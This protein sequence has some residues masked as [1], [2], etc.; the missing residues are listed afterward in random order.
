MWHVIV[1]LACWC[2]VS[3]VAGFML[4]RLFRRTASLPLHDV[5]TL[6]HAPQAADDS[7]RQPVNAESTAPREK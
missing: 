4:A 3:I 5:E 7:T 6:E 2:L 1:F